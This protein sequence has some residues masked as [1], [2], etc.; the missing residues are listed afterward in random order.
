M[1]NEKKQ[2][3]TLRISSANKTE[4]V[5]ILYEMLLDYAKEAGDAVADG[6]EAKIK[7]AIRKARG[8]TSELMGSIV[9]GNE[10]AE[11]LMSLYKYVARELALGDIRRDKKNFDNIRIVI[12]PLKDAYLEIMK[13]DDSGPV[14]TNTQTVV[15]GLT[16]SKNDINEALNESETRGFYV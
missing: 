2:E 4:L 10:L 3:Y 11:K 6:D 16:Y 12:E 14:M 15:A 5:E 9:P 13:K 7:E 8:C 1:T